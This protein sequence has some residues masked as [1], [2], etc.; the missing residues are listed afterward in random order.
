MDGKPLYEK[1]FSGGWA[2]GTRARTAAPGRPTSAM[3]SCLRPVPRRLAQGEIRCEAAPRVVAELV[4]ADVANEGRRVCVEPVAIVARLEQPWRDDQTLEGPV[5]GGVAAPAT[6][7]GRAPALRSL[8]G[9]F[10]AVR[11]GRGLSGRSLHH[12]LV[13][14]RT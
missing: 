5:R 3:R 11:S 12:R 4:L 9:G 1:A 2:L 8:G 13:A 7:A 14:S 10:A 6:E